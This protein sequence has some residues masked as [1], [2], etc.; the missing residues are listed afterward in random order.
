MV[1]AWGDTVG[2]N[3]GQG[4]AY[5][6]A[7]PNTGWVSTTQTAKFTA[8]DGAAN[9]QFGLAVAISAETDTVVVGARFATVGGNYEQGAAYVFTEPASGWADMTQTAKLTASDGRGADI[10]PGNPV[11]NGLGDTFGRSVAIDGQTDTVVVGAPLAM[12]SGNF[13]QGAAYVF[14]EP[15]SGWAGNL[16]QTQ[17]LT[18]SD[19]AANAEFGSAVAV[20]GNTMVATGGAAYVFGST[21]LGFSQTSLQADTINVA[22]SQT[23]AAVGGTGAVT[24]SVSNI[25]GV[26]PGLT[27]PS[28]G[29]GN[30]TISGTPT[31]SGTET[32]TVT[33]TDQAGDTASATYSILVN[34]AVTLSPATLQAIPEN[35]H[36]V[37]YIQ[38]S[39]GT[40]GQWL[41]VITASVTN[42]IPGLTVTPYGLGPG[43]TWEIEISG[44]PTA[45][46]TET[47]TVTATYAVGATTTLNYFLTVTGPSAV[48][49]SNWSGYAVAT[50]AAR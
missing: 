12:I 47:I 48:L 17:K 42:A 38:T 33:A 20:S 32:F 14:T 36:W 28:S 21:P 49:S 8:S 10:Y 31:K 30:L 44:T 4:A 43:G 26:I 41:T 35:V 9:D 37:G 3:A 13:E 39:G 15:A 50:S 40:G 27:V 29:T 22:Y 34:P 19:G 2:G 16:T 6:Y 24:L 11:L 5:V 46:G 25:S 7:E 1:G 18:A 23:I 45:T